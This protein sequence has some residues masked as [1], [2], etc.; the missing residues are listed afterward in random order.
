MDR[1][2]FYT[3]NSYA[4]RASLRRAIRSVIEDCGGFDTL[5]AKGRRVVIKPNLVMK[6]TPDSAATT[7][8]SVLEE[9][10]LLLQEHTQDITVVECPGGFSNAA[11]VEAVFRTTGV[12]AVCDLLG[13]PLVAEPVV[14]EVQTPDAF[15][16][17]SLQL[18]SEMLDADVFINVGKLKSHSLTAFTGCAK[19]LYGAVPGLFKVEYH[20]RFA[21]ITDFANLVCD[22]NRTL[23][24]TLNLLD[25]V[26]GMEGNGP[27]GGTPREI[28][29]I[30]GGVNAFAV[31]ALGARLL[32]LPLE[33]SPIL[34]AAQEKGL[35]S[36]EFV[37]VG[38]A[39][40][41]FVLKDFRFADA[42]RFSVLREMP[43]LKFLRRFLEPRP[44][45]SDRCVG[46]GECARLC[47]KETISMTGEGKRKKAR[48]RQKGCIRCYCCQELCPARAVDTKSRKFL[49]L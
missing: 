40:E 34:R 12:R 16:A 23:V 31:D 37:C 44:V 15:A 22:I 39:W 26:V 28:G 42:Q 8:P 3:C 7:H 30:L 38:D 18:A 13:V 21:E 32:S 10:I 24:P 9:L 5:F 17:G 41:P 4:D 33:R 11:A 14:R 35:F 47:P 46:C 29:G 27:T 45:I 36:E 19:N 1:V 2:S 25:A 48:I 43:N 20:A 49:K 6:K